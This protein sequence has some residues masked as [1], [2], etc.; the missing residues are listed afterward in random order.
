MSNETTDEITTHIRAL[1][2]IHA[3]RKIALEAKPFARLEP[4]RR[5]SQEQCELLLK[6]I[7]RKQTGPIQ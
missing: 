7:E 5:F 1:Y 3:D 2:E 4:A 6:E